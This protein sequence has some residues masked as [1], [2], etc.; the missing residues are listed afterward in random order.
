[1]PHGACRPP[2]W[3][4]KECLRQINSK[5]DLSI[6]LRPDR[7]SGV[8]YND[9]LNFRERGWLFSSLPSLLVWILCNKGKRKKKTY[10]SKSLP[11]C[12]TFSVSDDF[13][14][15]CA[16]WPGELTCSKLRDVLS[17]PTRRTAST[18]QML[19][20]LIARQNRSIESIVWHGH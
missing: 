3:H 7:L 20:Y 18:C 17:A 2:A 14:Y 1:M 13:F 19:Q 10:E 11:F 12:L 9:G 15:L 8:L 4:S 6:L 16:D 5:V